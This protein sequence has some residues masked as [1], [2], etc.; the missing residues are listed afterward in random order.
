MKGSNRRPIILILD[1]I[2]L[3]ASSTMW[4]NL[5]SYL[6]FCKTEKLKSQ[7]TLKILERA[8]KSILF[9]IASGWFSPIIGD[10]W[11]LMSFGKFYILSSKLKWVNSMYIYIYI[12]LYIYIYTIYYILHIHI[13][14][15]YHLFNTHEV[16]R[17]AKL[18]LGVINI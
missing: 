16:P 10:N 18:S 2:L 17:S 9:L 8:C 5:S 13:Y 6:N 7:W 3:Y 14:L 12:F 11:Y 1:W 15:F 4:I